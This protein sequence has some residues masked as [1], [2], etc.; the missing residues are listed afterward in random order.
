V[1]LDRGEGIFADLLLVLGLFVIFGRNDKFPVLVGEGKIGKLVT[2]VVLRV[3]G[4]MG[5]LCGLRVKY[6]EYSERN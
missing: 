5:R 6:E 2:R 4:W 3:V 1:I